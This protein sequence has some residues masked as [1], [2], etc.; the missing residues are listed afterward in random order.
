MIK[1]DHS[2]ES[3]AKHNTYDIREAY[4]DAIHDCE[5]EDANISKKSKVINS[6]ISQLNNKMNEL[7]V[8]TKD[9]ED[10][11]YELFKKTMKG[12]SIE[13]NQKLNIIKSDLLELNRQNREIE[14]VNTFVKLQSDCMKPVNFLK[15]WSSFKKYKKKLQEQKTTITDIQV[16]LKLDGK[17]I[18]TSDSGHRNIDIDNT[19]TDKKNVIDF[20]RKSISHQVAQKSTS[21]RSQ[22]INRATKTGLKEYNPFVSNNYGKSSLVP[23]APSKMPS[24]YGDPNKEFKSSDREDRVVDKSKIKRKIEDLLTGF[25]KS[26]EGAQLDSIATEAVKRSLYGVFAQNYKSF[27]SKV[28]S[29]KIDQIFK[30]VF[31]ESNILTDVFRIIL[32]LNLPVIENSN[33][34]IIPKKIFPV[35][36]DY[37]IKAMLEAFEK[38]G[39]NTKQPNVIVMKVDKD[40][41]VGGY[42]SDGW[43]ISEK[44]RGD[45]DCFL[46][47]LKQNF[48]FNAVP[49]K[50]FYQETLSK[51]GIKF[52]ERDLVIDND[53]KLVTSEIN[54]EHFVFGTHLLQNKLNSLIP[55]KKQ[56]EPEMVEV[57]TITDRLEKPQ[58]Q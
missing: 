52:G 57:W 1:G 17:P 47:N 11:I 26:L 10:E 54:G 3:T 12:L 48:R 39:L 41:I 50:P 51:D 33:D 24:S 22:L 35:S 23:A 38:K 18:I 5:T 55:D 53:F 28:S 21:F 56:F 45:G 13:Y 42:A 40:L 7:R 58:T 29:S 4:K 6:H 25:D 20:T 49:G 44:K 19:A 14:F 15:I 16:Q 37:S 8:C 27:K 2:G 9:V 43:S 34:L 36:N 31:K 32:Y 46:F 30:S